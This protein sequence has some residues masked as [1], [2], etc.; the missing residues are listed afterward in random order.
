[1]TK[2]QKQVRNFLLT[3]F[4]VFA[5]LILTAWLAI[6]ILKPGPEGRIVIAS[7]GADGAYNDLALVY[8]QKLK[9]FGVDVELR[10]RTAGSDTLT[11]L[12]DIEVHP[13]APGSNNKTSTIIDKVSDIDAGFLK[14]GVAG[15]LQGRQATDQE[16]GWHDR[17]VE[18]LQ[19]IGRL[20]Y[21][22]VYVFY[23][24]GKP[25]KSLSEFKGHKILIGTKQSGWR[26][27]AI[28]L[29]RA[30]GVDA[31]N[32]TFV[33]KDLSDDAAELK[34]GEADVAVLTLPPEST[35]I[36][37]LLHVQGI[38]LMDFATEADAYVARF[39]YL[40]KLVM[41]QGSIELAPDLPSADITL[42][43]TSAALVVKKTLHPALVALLSEVVMANPRSGFDR[44]GE[45]ILFHKAGDFPTPRDPEFAVAREATAVYK[46]GDL[47][48][49]LHS[50]APL[51]A[52]LG[53]PFWFTA[54]LHKHGT[55][56]ALLI[57]PLLSIALPLMQF[58]PKL[59]AWTVRR[60]VYQ[61]YRQMKAI[62]TR[63]DHDPSPALIAEA[64]QELNRIDRLAG[65]VKVPSNFSEMFYDLRGHVDLVR[66]RLETIHEAHTIPTAAQ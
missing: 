15:S 6:V 1:M 32:A 50:I 8:Q 9:R 35:T 61:W 56:T 25:V 21:E 29:L 22:P 7:G 52:S 14:G 31:K 19:S 46:T 66:R 53:I 51:N 57:I 59:Y 55:S 60:R 40:T 62:E 18:N 39:P 45:P 4:G 27:I 16:R 3:V 2:R 49:V 63:L 34:S 30:N 20:F 28:T 23:T 24:G 36:Q 64:H 5:G 48:F 33:E 37:K 11:S 43:A 10:P 54:Y 42:L 58:L 17:Q 65:R 41:H 47:P 12:L 38:Y 44:D 26:R 13:P